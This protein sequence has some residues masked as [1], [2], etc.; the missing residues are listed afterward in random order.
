[1]AKLDISTPLS[2]AGFLGGA[3]EDR[4]AL[5]AT[6]MVGALALLGLQD[7]LV[8]LT[9]SEVSLWQFQLLHSGCNLGFIFML[10]RFYR[11][12][13]SPYPKRVGAVVLR[14]LFLVA[15][16]IFF[17]GSISVSVR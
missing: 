16:M 1:M 6:L 4:P 11:G 2:E 5:A 3:R 9:S 8:K 10:S 15:A 17:F 14:S 12:G 7:S 13:F